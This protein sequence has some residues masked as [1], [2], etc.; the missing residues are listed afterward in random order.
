MGF[1]GAFLVNG[2]FLFNLDNF[3]FN[4][5]G[6]HLLRSDYRLADTL[7]LKLET[8][9]K[10]FGIGSTEPALS[11]QFVLI[12]LVGIYFIRPPSRLSKNLVLPTLFAIS[13]LIFSFLPNPAHTQY[14]VVAVPFLIVALLGA[15]AERWTS[16]SSSYQKQNRRRLKQLLTVAASVYI[17]GGIFDGYRYTFG[18]ENVPGIG[19]SWNA[20]NWKIETVREISGFLDTYSSQPDVPVISWWPGYFVESRTSPLPGMENN[21]GLAI[22][23][24]LSPDERKRYRIASQE[25]IETTIRKGEIELVVLDNRASTSAEFRERHRLLQENGFAIVKWIQ[26]TPLYKRMD[27]F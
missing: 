20:S 9:L 3:F 5:V 10:L 18:G 23:P 14:L 16:W 27:K 8:A 11:V 1:L 17:A 2:Y 4:N 15:V 12:S 21:F 24:K 7:K 25:E 19:W 13:L 22:A 6:Y 26:L